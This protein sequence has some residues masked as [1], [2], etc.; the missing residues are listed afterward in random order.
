M[1]GHGRATGQRFSPVDSQFTGT[2][3]PLATCRLPSA[4]RIRPS[5]PA[6][7]PACRSCSTS[8]STTSAIAR[9]PL[10]HCRAAR[11]PARAKHAPCHRT[12]NAD[13]PDGRRRDARLQQDCPA[14]TGLR[15]VALLPM[16]APP[17]RP[18]ETRPPSLGTRASG[19]VRAS[20]VD[21]SR[22][23]FLALY[24]PQLTSLS[25]A[26]AGSPPVHPRYCGAVRKALIKRGLA[27]RPA[28]IPR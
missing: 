18:V 1:E 8:R 7:A 16:W 13:R 15:F 12:G 23:V 27:L 4:G 24:L 10:V 5:G 9:T 19:R 22:I 21:G 11:G 2:V 26:R 14:A 3:T 25:L 20:R 17:P 28:A 6:S